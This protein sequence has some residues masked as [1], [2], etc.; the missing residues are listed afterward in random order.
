M[1]KLGMELS[2]SVHLVFERV[3]LGSMTIDETFGPGLHTIVGNA[4]GRALQMFRLAS[5]IVAPKRGRVTL[6][7]VAPHGSP[8]TRR[9]ITCLDWTPLPRAPDV[10]S[11]V[12]AV[13]KLR[14]QD[15]SSVFEWLRTFG[16]ERLW[17]RPTASLAP[18]EAA[19]VQLA[20]A[21]SRPGHRLLLL[22]APFDC[23]VDE[24]PLTKA[25]EH[26]AAV[27]PVLIFGATAPASAHGGRRLQL[28]PVTSPV[29]RSAQFAGSMWISCDRIDLL[30]QHLATLPGTTGVEL[31]QGDPGLLRV[32]IAL[33]PIS[34]RAA[35]SASA[36]HFA[37]QNG[38]SLRGLRFEGPET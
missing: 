10:R 30:A 32:G 14:D 9:T 31:L 37:R 19:R 33:E 38:L 25:L 29:A 20:M 27:R 18:R 16:D 23:G 5:G 7:G 8:E 6:R 35:I 34:V 22:W 4:T 1:T 26:V 24:G 28:G 2:N 3:P 13:A 15:V 17:E 36:L 21:L 12:G 11:L